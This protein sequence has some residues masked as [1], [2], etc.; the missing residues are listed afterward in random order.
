[1]FQLRKLEDRIVLDGAALI[2]A[3]DHF[4]DQADLAEHS[5]DTADAQTHE[6][7]DVHEPLTV[8]GL[9]SGA[10]DAGVHVLVV[11]S[12]ISDADDLVA[13]AKDNVIV[14]TY[15]AELS[16]LEDLAGQIADALGGEQADTIAFASHGSGSEGI[17][18][19]QSET[20][21]TKFSGFGQ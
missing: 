19:V 13:A 18:L 16:S 7:F 1:M 15:D 5:Q 6:G 11:S 20:I 10:D 2:D 12:D 4:Q 3:Q 9:A 14:V 8:D 17:E 21:N